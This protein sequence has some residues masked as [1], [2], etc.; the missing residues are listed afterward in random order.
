MLFE[1]NLVGISF[2]MP[3]PE[4]QSKEYEVQVINLIYL[5]DQLGSVD[6]QSSAFSMECKV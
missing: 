5:H 3:R 4:S 2:D 6:Q 1:R